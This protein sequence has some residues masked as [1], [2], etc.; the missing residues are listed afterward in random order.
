MSIRPIVND[1]VTG[2]AESLRELAAADMQPEGIA[3]C[4]ELLAQTIAERPQMEDLVEIVAT[5][6]QVTGV[7]NRDTSVVVSDLFSRAQKSVVV[8]GY[9]VYQGRKVFE[10]LSKRMTE[11]PDLNVRM[12]LDITRKPGDTSIESELV[13]RFCYQFRSTQWPPGARLPEIYYDPRSAT[14]DRSKAAALHAKCIVADDEHVFV[15]SAN[16]TQAGQNRNIELGLLLSSRL[17]G[18]RIS[19]FFRHLCE[20]EVLRRAI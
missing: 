17:V 12:Y 4:L 1:D 8:V 2:I 18:E 7:A 20:H 9:A 5:G 19:G 14:L 11:R 10:A 15:S 6:P 3:Q 13:K 16:F